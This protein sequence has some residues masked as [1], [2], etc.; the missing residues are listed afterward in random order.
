MTESKA[1]AKLPKR[2]IAVLGSE[3]L[4]IIL[5]EN[6]PPGITPT[7]DRVKIP[8]GGGQSFTVPT[9]EGE[10]LV[11]YLEGVIVA[12]HPARAYWASDFQGG[13]PPQC[14]SLDGITG[15]G[16]PGGACVTCK[17]AQWGSDFRDGEYLDG[18]ACKAMVRV[19]LLRE[20]E[21]L[22]ILVTLSPTSIKPIRQYLS[23][24]SRVKKG[25]RAV[26]TRIS[27]EKATSKRGQEY[28]KA[29]LAAVADIE[30]PAATRAFATELTPFIERVPV[31]S[32]EYIQDPG[33]ER[34]GEEEQPPATSD[35][36]FHRVSKT[37]S[38]VGY[39]VGPHKTGMEGDR[40]YTAVPWAAEGEGSKVN[41]DMVY[42]WDN[43][44]KDAA[45]GLKQGMRVGLTGFWLEETERA[46]TFIGTDYMILERP[47]EAEAATEAAP[48][49]PPPAP[50]KAKAPTPAAG[51]SPPPSQTEDTLP[52]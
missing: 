5:A 20:E 13:T 46:G 47:E 49:P 38:G 39:V 28:S 33:D 37:G 6:F 24:L 29:V 25:I 36:L 35:Q 27:L 9:V 19:Y 2:E 40:S 1:L 17:F 22:P 3:Q 14:S 42:F 31:Q 50:V 15:T 45:E 52:W 34:P 23:T 44:A 32:D 43:R 12:H 21:V 26:V 10:E 48:A 51:E 30:D 41:A 7:F 16:D 4:G 18:Q 8:T 11:K